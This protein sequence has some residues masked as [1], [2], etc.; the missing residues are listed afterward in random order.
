MVAPEYRTGIGFALI[1]ETFRHK[2]VLEMGAGS[3]VQAIYE[4]M[5]SRL[6]PTYRG[7]SI[8]NP[9]TAPVV[10]LLHRAAPSVLDRATKFACTLMNGLR[11]PGGRLRAESAPTETLLSEVAE[12]LVGGAGGRA[13]VA[14]TAELMRW[15]FFSPIGPRH[16]LVSHHA[17][18]EADAVAI[19]SLGFHRSLS[20][21]RIV[22]WWAPEDRAARSLAA[23]LR[24]LLSALGTN[25][26]LGL[27]SDSKSAEQWRSAGFRPVPTPPKEYELHRPRDLSFGPM[28]FCGGAGDVGFEALPLDVD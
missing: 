9:L 14:W 7:R 28:S 4:K 11:T 17:R 15:R 25:M 23:S 20:V 21:A 5:G 24:V 26:W 10:A 27:T 1:A 18:G 6:I 19:V 2:H 22:E 16:L 13:H 12:R 3:S 8:L